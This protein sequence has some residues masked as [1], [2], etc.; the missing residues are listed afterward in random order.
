MRSFRALVS[1]S[2]LSLVAANSIAAQTRSR[3]ELGTFGGYTFFDSVEPFDNAAGGGALFSFYIL[4]RFS[5]EG[6]ASFA[7]TEDTAGSQSVYL[8]IRARVLYSQPL[9]GASQLLAGTGFVQNAYLRDVDGVDYGAS[10]LIGIQLPVGRAIALRVDGVVDYMPQSI[11]AEVD[12]SWH[13]ALRAGVA[14]GLGPEFVERPG[15]TDSERDDV[16]DA[17]SD[18]DGVV[19]AEDECPETRSGA[20]VD[21][22][23]CELAADMDRDGVPDAED[24]CPGTPSGLAVDSRGCALSDGDGDGVPDGEDQCP[25]TPRGAQV[26]ALGCAVAVADADGD[27]V[28]DGDDDC[29]GT[30]AGVAV[31]AL[32]CP[33]WGDTDLDGVDDRQDACPSTPPGRAVDARGCRVP[34][35]TDADGVSDD[36]DHCPGTPARVE[37][38]DARGC[39]LPADADGDGVA[40][41]DD[42]CPGTPSGAV[43]NARGCPASPG[44]DDDVD[45]VT[46]GEDRC[47]GTFPGEAVDAAGCRILFDGGSTREI[48]EGVKFVSYERY[49]LTSQARQI[50]D[51]VA[52]WLIGHPD[53]RI[54]IASHT[55][56]REYRQYALIR[57]LGRASA[58]RRYLVSLGVDGSRLVARG[59]GPDQPIADNDTA[60][61]RARNDRI[62]LRRVE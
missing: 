11:I 13:F 61:G 12:E 57:S 6:E 2:I 16:A 14:V 55:D 44:S 28:P 38:V 3:F 34:L 52:R 8:P 40:D 41:A 21:R 5:L 46:N 53:V 45:G 32:G 24:A 60:A 36:D 43:V 51:G 1:L 27:G 48:L 31:N 19:D 10:G 9:I 7:T 35:D 47:P 18:R 15:P 59:Y 25:I 20:A 39:P 42:A 50:L 22:R 49:E 23:G 29:P 26:D 56:N 17:D 33:L 30:L 37:V 4:R 58:V 62:E 54:E